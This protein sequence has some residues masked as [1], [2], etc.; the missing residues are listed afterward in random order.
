MSRIMPVL[1]GEDDDHGSMRDFFHSKPSL[2]DLCARTTSAQLHSHIEHL[3]LK[4]SRSAV[5]TVA[6]TVDSILKF[7][8]VE[9]RAAPRNSRSPR[10]A[11]CV[12]RALALLSHA[13]VAQRGPQLPM[14]K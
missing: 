5:P 14:C 2:P 6:S 8:G 9:A 10:R 11:V 13:R 1:F 12:V 4:L 7:Q 3:D